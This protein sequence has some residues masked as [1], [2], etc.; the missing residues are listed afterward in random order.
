MSLAAVS[1]DLTVTAEDGALLAAR[2]D[3]PEDAPV[4]LVLAH[5]WTLDAS[6]W[7]RQ[8]EVLAG[9]GVRVVRYDQRGH[10]RS[11]G[12]I[13]PWSIDLLGRDLAR[14][15]EQTAPTG[16][17]VLGGH[18]MG[19]MTIMA[20]AAARPELFGSGA[21][22]GSVTKGGSG[23]EGATESG[24]AAGRVR[25]VLLTS[26]SAGRL[27]PRGRRE[28][29]LRLR[30]QGHVQS[31]F[32]GYCARTPVRSERIRAR[33]PGPEQ[34]LNPFLV[35][36]YLYGPQAPRS[37]VLAGARMIHGCPMTAVAGWY[38]ALMA[39]DKE[40]ALGALARVPVEVVVGSLDRLTPVVHSRRLVGELP[41][42]ALH[43]EPGCGHMLLTERPQVVAEP[44][45]RLC[46]QAT[47]DSIPV[48]NRHSN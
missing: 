17:V 37:A 9:E 5:G 38:P 40:G 24:A 21:E 33:L 13:A 47:R 43:I 35:K 30:V 46:Q 22:G 4:T 3:G 2:A 32:F 39:H 34:G 41:H 48:P 29:P 15:V 18:S 6:A 26:T 27:D 28:A 1:S 10:G 7:Q 23:A 31:A 45:R 12:G 11:Q 19:G 16:A 20:L 36:R 14:V 42:A 8:A 25:G 44:L